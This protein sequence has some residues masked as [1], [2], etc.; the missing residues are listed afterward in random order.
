MLTRRFAE[1]PIWS[2]TID[3]A[4]TGRTPHGTSGAKVDRDELEMSDGQQRVR[5]RAYQC[6]RAWTLASGR[7]VPSL[8]S[9]KSLQP[10]YQSVMCC[11]WCRSVVIPASQ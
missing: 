1:M 8:A 3:L 6:E 7:N 4:T 2:V 9:D 10:L 11:S 5:I